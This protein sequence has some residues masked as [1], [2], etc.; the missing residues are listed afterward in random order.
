MSHKRVHSGEKP[1]AC[2]L[3]SNKFSQSHHLTRHKKTH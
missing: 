2:E 1:Y 3:C